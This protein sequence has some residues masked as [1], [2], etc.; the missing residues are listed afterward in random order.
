MGFTLQ[1]YC[2]SCSTTAPGAASSKE[3]SEKT[4]TQYGW[5]VLPPDSTGRERHKCRDCKD[6]K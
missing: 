6:K 1:I 3:Q 2:N 5:Q 4:A